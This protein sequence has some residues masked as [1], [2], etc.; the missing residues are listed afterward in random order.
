MVAK[1]FSFD[2][3]EHIILGTDHAEVGGNILKQWSFPEELVNAVS[4][5]HNPEDCKN[6]C[7]LSDIVHLA[8]NLGQIIGAGRSSKESHSELSFAVIEKF[9]FKSADLEKIADQTL[10]GVNR[11]VDVL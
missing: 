10:K 8:N 3:A 7:M 9:G 6:Y 1:G 4:W 2:V 5:H 11:I